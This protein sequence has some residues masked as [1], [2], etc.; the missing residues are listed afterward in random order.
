MHVDNVLIG[1]VASCLC[2]FVNHTSLVQIGQ[3]YDYC[4]LH[5][6][7]LWAAFYKSQMI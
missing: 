7:L 1:L 4:K 6:K 5:I 2:R 3:M